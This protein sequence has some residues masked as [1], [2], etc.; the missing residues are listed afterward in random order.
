MVS[1]AVSVS[2]LTN[3]TQISAAGEST[4]ALQSTGAADDLN[5]RL[6]GKGVT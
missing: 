1:P 4:C 3:A 6:A 2:G 5:K